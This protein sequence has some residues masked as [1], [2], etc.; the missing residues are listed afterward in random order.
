MSDTPKYAYYQIV[1]KELLALFDAYQKEMQERRERLTAFLKGCGT[2][3]YISYGGPCWIAKIAGLKDVGLELPGYR[4][5]SKA[6]RGYLVPDRK[7]KEGKLEDKRLLSMSIPRATE[8]I[9][10]LGTEDHTIDPQ[11]GIWIGFYVFDMGDN[12]YIK[13]SYFTK[14][15][16]PD[17]LKPL[18][19]WEFLKLEEEYKEKEKCGSSTR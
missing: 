3:E 17:G 7:T 13:C 12:V 19:E 10:A 11:R 14:F 18:K 9:K 8:I 15:K 2:Q 4:K 16:N 6:E 5:G 1:G